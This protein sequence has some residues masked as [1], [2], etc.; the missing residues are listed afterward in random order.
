MPI[1]ISQGE[2]ADY[3]ESRNLSKLV[4]SLDKQ[5]QYSESKTIFS[6][7]AKSFNQI[8]QELVDNFNKL[9]FVSNDTKDITLR[10]KTLEYIQ[11]KEFAIEFDEKKCKKRLPNLDNIETIINELKSKT[12]ELKTNTELDI[13]E[14]DLKIINKFERLIE[15]KQ[16]FLKG[17]KACNTKKRLFYDKVKSIIVTKNSAISEEATFKQK[18]N[19]EKKN[20]ISNIKSYFEAC[21]KLNKS[22]NNFEKFD[23]K[24]KES[25]SLMENVKIVIETPDEMEENS[26]LDIAKSMFKKHNYKINNLYQTLLL[27]SRN[28]ISLIRVSKGQLDTK[29][30]SSFK[31]F[32]SFYDNPTESLFYN[33]TNESSKTKSPGFNAEQY[34]KLL[35]NSS[36]SKI[37]FIDQ[38]EDNLGNKFISEDLVED[39]RRIKFTKQIIL[40][41]HN[42]SIVVYGDAENVIMA[43]N[44]ENKISYRQLPLEMTENGKEICNALDGGSYI[45]NNRSRKY[46]IKR[47]LIE[48]KN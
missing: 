30:K 19:T 17:K 3:F 8:K 28:Q 47:L 12:S 13:S 25:I 36:N 34:L 4:D 29:L 22:S 9:I 37:I 38:P 40:V 5:K 39:F 7:K 31:E 20:L 41:T 27:L 44:D 15:L 11:I 33:N 21:T 26:I 23:Y 24:V 6:N 48:T 2:I 43:Y 46:N 18:A 1:Y 45:F 16:E 10:Q 42:P 14:D 35:I 32:I